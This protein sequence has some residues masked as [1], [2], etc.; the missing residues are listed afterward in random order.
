M[1]CGGEHPHSMSEMRDPTPEDSMMYY[2]GEMQAHNFWQDAESDTMLRSEDARRQFI[3]GFKAGLGMEKSDAAYNKGV[4]LGLRLAIRLREFGDRYGKEFP[5]DILASS[6]ENNVLTDSLIDVAAAQKGFYQIKDRFELEAATKE[7][8]SAMK[9][10]AEQAPQKGFK[11][12]S[13]TL[14]AKDITPRGQGPLLK[15]GDRIAVE[16][17]AS[18]LDGKEI[19]TRQFPDSITIGTG[20]VPL[21]VRMGILTMTSGQTRS[22]MTTPR[23][24]FGKRY[25]AYHLPSDEPVIFTVKVAQN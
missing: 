11:M 1:S 4:Q 10:L 19:V 17:T 23:T 13:D 5:E 15:E 18:T 3:E 9:K 14:Y 25:A 22:F 16:V 6:L 12:V 21:I 20:R 2:F 8:S 24:L 7:L